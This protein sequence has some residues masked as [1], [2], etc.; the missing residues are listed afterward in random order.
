MGI[1]AV[2]FIAHGFL[3]QKEGLATAFLLNPF[4]SLRF[5]IT[6]LIFFEVV[7]LF[8]SEYPKPAL[9]LFSAI[10]SGFL[11]NYVPYAL[12]R[13]TSTYYVMKNMIVLI[14]FGMIFAAG[15][16]AHILR[17]FRGSATVVFEKAP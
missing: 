17:R 15:A 2:V 13:A 16:L 11:I 7:F 1:Y 9:G 10:T 14:A 3:Q 8:D 5:W 4:L 12:F 6:A